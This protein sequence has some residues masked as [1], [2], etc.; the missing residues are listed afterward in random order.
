LA[1]TQF[2]LEKR[3]A[4]VENQPATY[5]VR[6]LSASATLV[7]A[8][9][10]HWPEYLFEGLELGAF[11]LA[12]CTF[13]T[14]LFYSESP[15]V[16][17][18]PSAA[19]R[20][21]LMGAAMGGTAIGIILSPMGRRSGAHFNP[22]VSFTF[23]CLGKMHRLDALLYIVS[24]F[25]GG[26]FGVLVARIL[27]GPPLA[28][29]SVRYVVTVPGRYGVPL[30]FLAE[31]FMGLLTMTVVLQ[32]TNRPRLSRVTWLLVGLLVATYVIAFSPVSGF[33]L[34]PARTI[35]SALFAGVWTVMWLYLTA[36]LL[37][38]LV[39]ASLYVLTSGSEAVLCAKIY[40]DFHS[41]CP[42]RCCFRRLALP[43]SSASRL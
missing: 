14:L 16:L 12:A 39:A 37:G 21:V 2:L 8:I 40:H 26:A 43:E 28:S 5:L 17:S 24:Q 1:W 33:S 13:G 30:A 36:P 11:M 10:L 41:P 6:E 7:D 25:A 3:K 29:P 35:S 23:F 27:I 32:S 22:V 9:A 20:L 18:V 31:F 19:V 34:N 15:V 4:I 38:M 42:F